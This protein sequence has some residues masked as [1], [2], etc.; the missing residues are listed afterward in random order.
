MDKKYSD[1][2][3][4]GQRSQQPARIYEKAHPRG[5]Y[6]TQKS[7]DKYRNL[8][9]SQRTFIDRELDDLKFGQN[10][11]KSNLNNSEL[12]QKI[13]FDQTDREV[14]ITDILYRPYRQSRDYQKA[15]IRMTNMNN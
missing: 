1:K 6:Y 10:R 11:T 14:L 5:L 9:G 4:R 2:N 13:V 15:Q 7:I 8:T 3:V 12:K